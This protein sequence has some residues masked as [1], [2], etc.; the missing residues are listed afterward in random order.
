MVLIAS[1]FL[2]ATPDTRTVGEKLFW[3]AFTRQHHRDIR[4][5][6]AVLQLEAKHDRHPR[7]LL[8]LG[9]THV[10]RLAEPGLSKLKDP[11]EAA[12]AAV[13]ALT[14]YQQLVPGDPRVASWLAP[15]LIGQANGLREGAAHAPPPQA[16]AMRK[17]AD[18]IAARAKALIDEG[19][20]RE[21]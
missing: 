19:V 16:E 20:R 18:E 12:Q 1:L 11:A 21:P 14:R 17:Q 10:W 9:V 8:L 6:V 13:A 5:V 2:L 3:H 4:S 15:V 7:S